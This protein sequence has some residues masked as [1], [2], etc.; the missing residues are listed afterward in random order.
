[1]HRPTSQMQLGVSKAAVAD[2]PRWGKTFTSALRS[3][4]TLA[5]QL[6]VPILEV[7]GLAIDS[8]FR[9]S[10]AILQMVFAIYG[11][12]QSLGG[13]IGISTV[14]KRHQAAMVLRR[15]GGQSLSHEGQEVPAYFDPS[16][17]CEMELLKFYSWSP[18]TR[19]QDRFAGLQEQLFENF[20]PLV[21]KPNRYAN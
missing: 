2:D 7:G 6:Q 9:G 20:P 21:P 18:R 15:L 14:T 8:S 13:A 10:T 3:E 5:Q 4:I 19:H 1:M 17:G 11:L 16:Y 12:A